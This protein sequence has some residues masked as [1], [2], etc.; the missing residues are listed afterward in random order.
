MPLL[1]IRLLLTARGRS[2]SF[3]TVLVHGGAL[4]AG[5]NAS[6]RGVRDRIRE[7]NNEAVAKVAAPETQFPN[8]RSQ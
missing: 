4:R 1:L 3:R 6:T 7:T 2:I 5:T 8:L